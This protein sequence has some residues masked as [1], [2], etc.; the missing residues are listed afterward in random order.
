MTE[1]TAKTAF[2]KTFDNA[3]G[4]YDRI[5]PDYVDTIYRGK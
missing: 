1:P 5:R 2:E 4:D 3:A